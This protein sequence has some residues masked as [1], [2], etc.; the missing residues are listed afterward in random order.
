MSGSRDTSFDRLR[1]IFRFLVT[2]G[3]GFIAD[4]GVLWLMMT[5]TPAGPILARCVSFP[6]ALTVTW[7]LNRSWSFGDRERP[8][9]SA[10]LIGYV[11]IQVIGFLVNSGIYVVLVLGWLG[12]S[13]PALV[14]LFFGSGT[15]AFV[16]FALLNMRLYRAAD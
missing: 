6:A 2:G 14:A 12:F 3:A 4:A 1:R 8:H 7:I 11:T 15:S 16:T 13:L 10:E 9:L 5:F